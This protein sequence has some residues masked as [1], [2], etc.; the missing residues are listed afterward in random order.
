MGITFLIVA[1]IVG[2]GVAFYIRR[3]KKKKDLELLGKVYTYILRRP[4]KVKK[5]DHF[6]FYHGFTKIMWVFVA[7]LEFEILP[8]DEIGII[9]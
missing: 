1:I 6:R 4:Q 3:W 2:I 8:P 5:I 9:E 7:L